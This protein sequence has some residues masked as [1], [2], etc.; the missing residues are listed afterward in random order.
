MAEY[1]RTN[2]ETLYLDFEPTLSQVE[3]LAGYDAILRAARTGT[4]QSAAHKGF[5]ACALVMHAMRSHEMMTTM[6]EQPNPMGLDAWEYL[7]LLKQAWGNRLLLARAVTP[8]ALG[9]WMFWRTTDHSLPL[10]DSPVIIGRDSVLAILSPRLLLT[11]DL[12]RSQPQEEWIIRDGMP[13]ALAAEVQARTLGNTFKALAFSDQ[14]TLAAWQVTTA[15]TERRALLGDRASRLRCL[16]EATMRVLWLLAGAG[17]VPDDFESWIGRVFDR[18]GAEQE[19][20]AIRRAWSAS[21]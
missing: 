19:T 15:Y 16:R 3:T 12:H 2:N 7:W 14:E 6:L 9:E 21:T 17:R 5:V 18:P 11:I 20:E 13:V 8:L 1:V 10:C 4:L